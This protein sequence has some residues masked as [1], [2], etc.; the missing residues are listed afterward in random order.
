MERITLLCTDGS[1]LAIE[2]LRASLSLL[3]PADRTVVVT[4][5]SPVAANTT[6]GTGFHATTRAALDAQVKQR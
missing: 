5:E 2:A 3:A 6:T 1:E 4:V